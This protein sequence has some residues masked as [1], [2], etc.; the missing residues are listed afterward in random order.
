MPDTVDSS[1]AVGEVSHCINR[2]GSIE[3]MTMIHWGL[4]KSC[5]DTAANRYVI[6]SLED[7]LCFG[8]ERSDQTHRKTRFAVRD[9]R[10]GPLTKTGESASKFPDHCLYWI[11][12]VA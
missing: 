10:G 6:V 2:K 3:N 9:Y 5:I 4:R 8:W 7:K 11:I 1:I 12:A